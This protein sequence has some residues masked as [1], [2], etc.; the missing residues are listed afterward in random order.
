MKPEKLISIVK[1]VIIG[2]L[3]SM[4]ILT[5]ASCSQKLTFLTSSLVPAAHGS[6]KVVKESNKNYNITLNVTNLAEV[7][8]LDPPRLFYMVWMVDNKGTTKKIGLINSDD[9]LD[10]SIETISLFKPVS[11]LITAEIDETIHD[12]GTQVVLSTDKFRY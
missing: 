12:P 11:F 8:R 2:C 6:I 3:A 1:N 10:S 9:R 7:D 5:F 4:M